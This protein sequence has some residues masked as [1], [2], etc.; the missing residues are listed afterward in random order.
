MRS[1]NI[2]QLLSL[3]A[4]P[5]MSST[6]YR[7][8]KVPTYITWIVVIICLLPFGLNLLGIDFGTPGQ[9]FDLQDALTW[10]NSQVVD[11]MH[12]ALA[13]SFVHT[14]LEWSACCSALLIVLLSFM[15]YSVKGNPITPTL[16]LALFFAGVMDAFHTLASDRLI[17]AVP[18]PQNLVPFTW[19]MCRLFHALIMIGG[20]VI[21]MINPAINH[22]EHKQRAKKTV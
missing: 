2:E 11:A 4:P 5:T 15:N 21:L 3:T 9:S 17:D 12:Y 6:S 8:H 7:E 13:G 19:A 18:E 10:E 22:P 16:G 14:I 20:V 1:P